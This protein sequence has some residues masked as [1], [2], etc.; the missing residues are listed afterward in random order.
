MKPPSDTS[1]S[2]PSPRA[3]A[4]QHLARLLKSG[5]VAGATLLG[6]NSSTSMAVDPLPPACQ[7]PQKEFD[8]RV[9]VTA[10]WA[11]ATQL[12]VKVMIDPGVDLITVSSVS[13]AIDDVTVQAFSVLDAAG[14]IAVSVTSVSKLVRVGI[15][16]GGYTCERAFGV[17]VS[18]AHT[19]GTAVAV[20]H[21]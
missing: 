5:T 6:C 14:Q 12:T 13:V 20:T 17:D 15:S 9:H 21:L 18:G 2:Q 10:V 16:Y 8:M 3:R 7:I 1:P 11:S 19:V 4:L